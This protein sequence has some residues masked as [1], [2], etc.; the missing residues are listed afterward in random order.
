M[1]RIRTPTDNPI[2]SLNGWLKKETFINFNDI[3]YDYKNLVQ[4]MP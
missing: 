2:K 1:S 4:H 3:I